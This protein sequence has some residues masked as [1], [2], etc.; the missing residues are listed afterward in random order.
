M[1]PKLLFFYIK[2]FQKNSSKDKFCI[3][4]K[5]SSNNVQSITLANLKYNKDKQFM[6]KV[7][8][9]YSSVDELRPGANPIEEKYCSV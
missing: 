4:I 5:L 2:I 1:H 7:I 9:L 8:F 3:Q 6:F